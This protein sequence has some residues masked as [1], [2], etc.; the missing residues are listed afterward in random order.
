MNK[1]IIIIFI[2]VI[3]LCLLNA[4]SFSP[5]IVS[6]SASGINS[7]YIYTVTND[8]DKVIPI[9]ISINEFSKDI[10][11]NHIQGEIVYDDF[12]I[13]PAQFILDA[14]ESRSVQVRWTGEPSVDIEKNYTILCKQVELPKKEIK[15]D[16]LAVLITVKMNYQGRLYIEPEKG[17]PNIMLDAVNSP[18][19]ENGEQ[20]LEFIVENIGNI[21]GDLSDYC[22][23]L[24]LL[25]EEKTDEVIK[26]ITLTSND[27][28]KMQ[29]SVLA[30]IKRRYEIPWPKEIPFGNVNVELRKK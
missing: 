28:P 11:G 5:S 19:N 10:D 16:K 21:H 27:I 14:G 29:S 26:T 6:F 9:D 30:G 4:Y 1:M 17:S 25:N 23:E 15:S 24:N 12:I 22:F 7:S 13:Y 20:M 2:L 8:A 3:K 18:V